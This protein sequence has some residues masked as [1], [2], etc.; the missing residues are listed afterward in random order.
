MEQNKTLYPLC[1]LCFSA[2][3]IVFGTNTITDLIEF[4]ERCTALPI[5]SFGR[6]PLCGYVYS[7]IFDTLRVSRLFR[8]VAQFATPFGVNIL[9]ITS[10]EI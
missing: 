7:T 5:P 6:T 4:G 1:I 9:A 3:A 2:K 10:V 8:G